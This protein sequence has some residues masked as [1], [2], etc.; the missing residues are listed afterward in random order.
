MLG[1]AIA[2]L[3]LGYLPWIPVLL[4][5]FSRPETEW[6]GLYPGWGYLAPLYQGLAG[7]IIML[8]MLPVERQPLAIA[9]P[10]GFL[11]ITFFLWITVQALKG[12]RNFSHQHPTH[13]ALWLI[14]STTLLILLQY[15]A[16][17]YGLGKDLTLAPRYNFV[18]FPGLWSLLALALTQIPSQPRRFQS[19]KRL[20]WRSLNAARYAPGLAIAA[21]LLSSILVV[22]NLSFYKNPDPELIA[23]QILNGDPRWDKTSERSTAIAFHYPSPQELALD[24]SITLRL[25][26]AMPSQ[27]EQEVA[28]AFLPYPPNTVPDWQPLPVLPGTISPPLHLWN[29]AGP[30]SPASPTALE[31]PTATQAQARCS[32]NPTK[33]DNLFGMPYQRYRCS[34]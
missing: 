14:S 32:T 4:T 19:S 20:A 29:F 24:L 13:P 33:P 15:L 6:L 26:P 16:I 7:W 12:W 21:G 23:T 30:K 22:H 11:M 8:V 34:S 18:Y 1:M 9:I 2:I 25:Q 28:I 10:L 31:I 27:A 17:I 5:H 3:F